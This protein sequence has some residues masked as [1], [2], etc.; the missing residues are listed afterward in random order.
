M[1]ELDE[2]IKEIGLDKLSEYIY[3]KCRA[4]GEYDFI[5]NINNFCCYCG[6]DIESGLT[7]EE[8]EERIR[9]SF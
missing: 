3:R 1:K 6:K 8:M 4:C 9:D 2:V 7:L 5:D